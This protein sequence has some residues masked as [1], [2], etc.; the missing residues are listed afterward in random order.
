MQCNLRVIIDLTYLCFQ[1]KSL[2]QSAEEMLSDLLSFKQFFRIGE[3]LREEI[4]AYGK[5]KY[6]YWLKDISDSLEDPNNPIRC[7]G[8]V[9][10]SR[11]SSNLDFVIF[12]PFALGV[13][14]YH[15]ILK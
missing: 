5:D 11:Y 14:N 7:V 13:H 15:L 6:E 8:F 1:V 4:E 2:M 12:H 3:E 9:I 10:S